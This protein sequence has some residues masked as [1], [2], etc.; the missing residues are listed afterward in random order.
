[1]AFC[2]TTVSI[3]TCLGLIR[4]RLN[5]FHLLM[6]LSQHHVEL[7]KLFS[8]KG[9]THDQQFALAV[10]LFFYGEG[11]TTTLGHVHHSDLPH[12]CCAPVSLSLTFQNAT[13]VC[14][15][16]RSGSDTYMQRRERKTICFDPT[17]A[18]ILHRLHVG[19]MYTSR[20]GY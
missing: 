17:V 10:P 9:P 16:R 8:V 12:N 19:L 6:Y 5:M 7:E 15:Q 18:R 20:M 11:D 2:L 14:D 1:M 3:T 4:G 13:A